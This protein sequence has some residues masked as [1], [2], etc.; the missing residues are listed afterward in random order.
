MLLKT[1]RCPNLSDDME[2]SFDGSDRKDSDGENSN[3]E[4]FNKEFSNEK[5]FLM[6]KIKYRM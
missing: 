1:K 6:N 4:N 5:N 2:I 3:E